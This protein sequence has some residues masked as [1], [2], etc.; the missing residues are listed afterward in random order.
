MVAVMVQAIKTEV[1]VS[2]KLIVT[3][4]CSRTRNSVKAQDGTG[5][6]SLLFLLRLQDL[7]SLLKSQTIL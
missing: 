7:G 2:N 5:E 6:D 4:K 3:I 1:A